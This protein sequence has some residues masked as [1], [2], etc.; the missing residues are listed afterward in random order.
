MSTT[1]CS[2]AASLQLTS[3]RT[4]CL[5]S[6]LLQTSGDLTG[7]ENWLL[8]TRVSSGTRIRRS[9]RTRW[10]RRRWSAR[11]W[12]RSTPSTWLTPRWFTGW[13]RG[14]RLQ[15]TGVTGLHSPSRRDKRGWRGRD[16]R[17]QSSLTWS[18]FIIID[19]DSCYFVVSS[20]GEREQCF[21]F[22]ILSHTCYL[23]SIFLKT[24][25]VAGET[26]WNFGSKQN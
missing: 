4:T 5:V 22:L 21:P 16:T 23:M 11:C 17:S 7:W 24:Y 13:E 12:L 10:G 9:R 1:I 26:I 8:L 18:S 6:T 20:P 3:A 14:P 2:M 19:C 25:F 15:C